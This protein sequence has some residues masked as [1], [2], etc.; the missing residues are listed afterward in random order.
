[1]RADESDAYSLPFVQDV[2]S[3]DYSAW[4]PM[5]SLRYN[6]DSIPVRVS[7]QVFS[8]FI[9]GHAQDSATSGFHIVYTIENVSQEATDVALAG[10]LDNPIASALPERLTNSLLQSHDS[11]SI[12]F[13][14]AAHSDFPSGIGNLCLSITGPARSVRIGSRVPSAHFIAEEPYTRIEFDSP[15]TLAADQTMTIQ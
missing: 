6:D 15:V 13:D 1:L 11:T 12:F 8:P 5:T 4:F 2:Q 10:F 3:I 7:A 9:P 14:T